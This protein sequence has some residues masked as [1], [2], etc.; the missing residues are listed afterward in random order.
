LENDS[1]DD[2]GYKHD[3]KKSKEQF[4][5]WQKKG[6][7]HIYD[8]LDYT[9][10]ERVSTIKEEQYPTSEQTDKKIV[11]RVVPADEVPLPEKILV[12]SPNSYTVDN[13]L[14]K[15][16]K[17]MER[18]VKLLRIGHSLSDQEL[19]SKF[20]I[21]NLSGSNL[22]KGALGEKQDAIDEAKI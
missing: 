10:Q 18:R 12:V 9:E 6:Y 22:I 2:E 3:V 14:Q 4:F 11:L 16:S 17:S 15:V 8:E 7:K 20:S 13:L 5:P 21:E 1:S 19:N